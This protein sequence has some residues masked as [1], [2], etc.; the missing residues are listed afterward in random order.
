MTTAAE[1]TT[2][3]DRTLHCRDCNAPFI[4]TAAEQRFY[5]DKGLKHQPARCKG[6]RERIKVGPAAAEQGVMGTVRWFDSAKG[7]GFISRGDEKR[8]VFV[9]Y[10]AIVGNGYRSLAEGQSVIF[11]L[12]NTPKGP[13]AANVRAVEQ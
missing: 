13:H 7:Y 10:T 12:H 9:H 6:C 11:D 5:A 1:L 3:E 2:F 4:W 8:E